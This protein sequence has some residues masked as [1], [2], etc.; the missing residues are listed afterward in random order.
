[1]NLD[2]VIAPAM[3]VHDLPCTTVAARLALDHQEGGDFG[4]VLFLVLR[5]SARP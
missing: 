1:M 5:R 2:G 3:P 4:R